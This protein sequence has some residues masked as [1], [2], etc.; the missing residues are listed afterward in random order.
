MNIQS[1][2]ALVLVGVAFLLAVG[3]TVKHKGRGSCCDCSGCS[4]CAKRSDCAKTCKNS[5]GKARGV[6]EQ[7]RTERVEKEN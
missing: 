1:I 5:N 3:Y 6:A 4:G 7:N 2:V